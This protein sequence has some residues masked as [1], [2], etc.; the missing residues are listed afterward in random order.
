M[1]MALESPMRRA[2]TLARQIALR[3]RPFPMDEIEAIIDGVDAPSVRDALRAILDGPAP[4][5]VYL[6]PEGGGLPD[7]LAKAA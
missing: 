7:G 6:G 1:L 5:A 3:G 2:E 4:S